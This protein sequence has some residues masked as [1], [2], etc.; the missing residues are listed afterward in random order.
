MRRYCYQKFVYNIVINRWSII[1]L[2]FFTGQAHSQYDVRVTDRNVE[3][4]LY[5]CRSKQDHL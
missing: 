4:L 2:I 5:I 3:L 1:T